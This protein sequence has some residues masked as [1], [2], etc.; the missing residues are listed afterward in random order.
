MGITE[1]TKDMFQRRLGCVGG[2]WV[3]EWVVKPCNKTQIYSVG[4]ERTE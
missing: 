3:A 1:G 2:D 4:S